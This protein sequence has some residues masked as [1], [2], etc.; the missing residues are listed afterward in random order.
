MG[1]LDIDNTNNSNIED[2][3]DFLMKTYINRIKCV[4][5]YPANRISYIYDGVIG[6]YENWEDL[7]V[8]SYY[9]GSLPIVTN[10]FFLISKYN[11]LYRTSMYGDA[12]NKPYHCDYFGGVPVNLNYIIKNLSKWDC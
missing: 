8:C 5:R 10:H 7:M 12:T 3:F 9:S 6:E 1:L 4:E 11:K 2:L